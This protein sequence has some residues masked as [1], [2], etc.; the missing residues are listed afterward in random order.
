MTKKIKTI[1]SVTLVPNG[2]PCSLEECPPGPFAKG[3]CIG[4]K[5]EYGSTRHV[6]GVLKV[7]NLPDVYCLESGEAYCGGDPVLPLRVVFEFG[8]EEEDEEE[9][10]EEAS[11]PPSPALRNCW[12][13]RWASSDRTGCNIEDFHSVWPWIQSTHTYKDSPN[14]CPLDAN[15]CPGWQPADGGPDARD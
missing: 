15:G 1:S 3:D 5:T 10:E 7:T 2:W 14:L 13:C 9:K 4:F 6:D 8:E 11:Q 12:T